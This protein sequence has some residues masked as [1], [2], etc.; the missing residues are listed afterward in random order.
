MLLEKNVVGKKTDWANYITLS[1]E[2]ETPMLRVLPKGPKPVN[3][4]K[5]YQSDTYDAPG[6]N[7]WADGKDWATFKSAGA[8]RKP[9]SARI[10]WFVKTAAVSKLAEDVTDTAGITDELAHEIPKKMTEMARDMEAA[11]ASDQSSVADAGDEINGH[12]FRSVGAW[13]KSTANAD[14]DVAVDTTILPPSASI[15]TST[16]ANLTEDAVKTLLE[17]QWKATGNKGMKCGFVGSKLKKRFGEFQFYIPTSLSTQATA[18]IITRGEDATVLGNM[19]DVYDSDWGKVEL[20][21]TRWNAATGVNGV[22]STTQGDWRGYFLNCERW[23]WLWNQ[24]PTVYKPEFKG[25]SYKAA[26]DAIVMFLCQNPV[27]EAKIDPSDA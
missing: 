11:A 20:H 5:N 19:V 1:D 17:S 8:N 4:I 2:H 26:I 7:A 15:Y 13:V 22:T 3:V 9:L 10:Q 21:L 18:R 23:A 27:G 14:A 16:K 12:K 24:K 25:G 6:D